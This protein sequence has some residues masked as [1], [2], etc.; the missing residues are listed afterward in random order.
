MVF[1]MFSSKGFLGPIG[2]DLPSL[3]PLVFS[4]VLFFT[5]FTFAFNA[6]ESRNSYFDDSVNILTISSSLKQGSYILNHSQFLESCNGLSVSRLNF[7]VALVSLDDYA[8]G[9]GPFAGN[10]RIDVE[11]LDDL[12]YFVSNPPNDSSALDKNVF[13]C[14]NSS[15]PP[16]NNSNNLLLRLY[17]VTLETH[18]FETKA[19]F[20]VKPMLMVVVTWHS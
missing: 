16:K 13:V 12:A 19:G 4:L 20:A 2:D 11:S 18:E 7:K 17:P 3:I 9:T 1:L 6:F 14:S 10:Q 8:N 15:K 5:T